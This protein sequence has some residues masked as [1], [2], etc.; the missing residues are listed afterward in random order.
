VIGRGGASPARARGQ[1]VP[2]TAPRAQPDGAA[3]P[4]SPDRLG[5][6]RGGAALP[7]PSVPIAAQER[8]LPPAVARAPVPASS[9]P[10]ASVPSGWA[11]VS[12]WPCALGRD[13]GFAP[14]ASPAAE[15]P[16]CA[17]YSARAADCAEPRRDHRPVRYPA[18]PLAPATA[19]AVP[20]ELRRSTSRDR[21]I[22]ISDRSRAPTEP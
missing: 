14:E 22:S 18:Y 3:C 12:V 19:A 13:P 21:Y 8:P 6:C 2:S 10:A 15:P 5:R 9:P 4:S 16:A 17:M 1:A 20:S 7:V 11:L